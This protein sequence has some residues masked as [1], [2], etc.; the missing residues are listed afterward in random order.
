MRKIL[1]VL[2]AAVFGLASCQTNNNSPAASDGT[3][4]P[5]KKIKTQADSLSYALGVSLGEQVRDMKKNVGDLDLEMFLAAIR[6]VQEN[7][8]TLTMDQSNE[9]LQ[10]YFSFVMPEKNKAE[11][12]KFLADV[13]KTNPNIKK[14]DSGVLYDIIE[15]GSDVRATNL[16][17]QVRVMYRGMLKDGT[18]F[19]SSYGPGRDTVQFPLNGVIQGWGEGLQLIGEGGKIKLWIPSDLGY[20]EQGYY[21]IGPNEPL[22]FEVELFSVI[23]SEE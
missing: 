10:H 12:A 4:K 17:D 2:A 1:I 23:P 5:G 18:E 15:P 9:F 8:Y 3:V 16:A 11:G 13:Q 21:N 20:G 22:V 14:T 7:K 19:D 6:D